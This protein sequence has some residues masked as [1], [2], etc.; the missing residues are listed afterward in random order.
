METT[1]VS[2]EGEYHCGVQAMHPSGWTGTV[3]LVV[4]AGNATHETVMAIDSPIYADEAQ[5]LAFA[6]GW[7]RNH[8][9][10][11]S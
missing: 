3:L 5:A 2:A 6:E 7:A 4:R 8:G 10:V 9:G 11:G 1:I